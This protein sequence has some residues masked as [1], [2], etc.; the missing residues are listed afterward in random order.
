MIATWPLVVANMYVE[1]DAAAGQVQATKLLRSTRL[2]LSITGF[3]IFLNLYAQ[4]VG[5]SVA[6]VSMVNQ[7]AV[8]MMATGV[9]N[10]NP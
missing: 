8:S 1:N 4:R 5:M 6:I 10:S 9:C 7:T 2:T 3:F